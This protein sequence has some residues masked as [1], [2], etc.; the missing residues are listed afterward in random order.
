MCLCRFDRRWSRRNRPIEKQP[1]ASTEVWSIKPDLQVEVLVQI[2]RPIHS[3]A[4]WDGDGRVE[5]LVGGA[6]FERH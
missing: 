1:G 6:T 2:D 5:L 4:D 3:V